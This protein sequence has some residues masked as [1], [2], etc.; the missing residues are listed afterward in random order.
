MSL[1]NCMN[2]SLSLY[3]RS[4]RFIRS[5]EAS[6]I[7]NDFGVNLKSALSRRNKVRYSALEVNIL[8]GSSV[9]LVIKSSINTPI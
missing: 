9:P 3:F 4:M 1:K 7:L 2:D 5:S 6:P 8:Y